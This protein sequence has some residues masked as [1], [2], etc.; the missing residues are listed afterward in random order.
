VKYSSGDLN[1]KDKTI[2]YNLSIINKIATTVVLSPA[3]NTVPPNT[4]TI[5]S[6][7]VTQ[8]DGSNPSGTVTITSSLGGSY[9][10]SFTLK[11]KQTGSCQIPGMPFGG[12][13]T[14]LAT[15]TPTD[16]AKISSGISN[17]ATVTVS[18]K[19]PTAANV[20]ILD[21]SLQFEVRNTSPNNVALNVN[22]V[23]VDW[24]NIPPNLLKDFVFVENP[25][26]NSCTTNGT[27]NICLWQYAKQNS[28]DVGVSN[29]PQKF[30]PNSPNKS[31]WDSSLANI[32]QGQTKV[33]RLDFSNAL[34]TGN[35]I[36]ITFDQ[37]CTLS[38]TK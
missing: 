38:V 5:F 31:G 25:S 24:A 3:T 19:C 21:S 4:P 1:Y 14:F 12:P 37:G 9:T 6:V 13:Y 2:T 20:N 15:F 36:Q 34:G 28:T 17:T 23:S 26:S 27:D 11:N 29:P 30:G 32:A 18:S 8:A 10:C 35:T 22:E 16:T 33:F 7:T